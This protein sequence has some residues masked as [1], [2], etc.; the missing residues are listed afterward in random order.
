ML[1]LLTRSGGA[2]LSEITVFLAGAPV[3]CRVVDISGPKTTGQMAPTSRKPN[4]FWAPKSLDSLVT[5]VQ[6]QLDDQTLFLSQLDK[7]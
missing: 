7:H 1:M 3:S 5:W 4:R 6:D 2:A